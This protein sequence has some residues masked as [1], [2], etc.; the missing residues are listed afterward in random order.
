V[1][2]LGKIRF[3]GDENLLRPSNPLVQLRD[4]IACCGLAPLDGVFPQGRLEPEWIPD[5][6]RRGWVVIT[7]DRHLRTRPGE[8]ELAVEY[9]LKVVHLDGSGTGHDGTN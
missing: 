2:E 3:V 7:D 9:R 1:T 6:G 4:D 8:A 5:I